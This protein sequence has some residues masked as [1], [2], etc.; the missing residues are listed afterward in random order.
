MN[1][2]GVTFLWVAVQAT[3]LSAVAA[4]CYVFAARRG[5]DSA[6][7]VTAGFLAALVVLPFLALCPLP[8]WHA[9]EASTADTSAMVRTDG[10]VELPVVPLHESSGSDRDEVAGSG[11]TTSLSA[12]QRSWQKLRRLGTELEQPRWQWHAF[13]ALAILAGSAV[14]LVRILFGMWALSRWCRGRRVDDQILLDLIDALRT[15]MGGPASVELRELHELSAPAT[16]G[17]LRPVILLPAEWRS[18]DESERRSVLAHEWAHVCRRDYLAALVAHICV[19][20][21]FYHPLV[22]WLAGRLHLQQELEADALGARCAGGSG[23]YLRALANLALRQ[24]GRPLGWPAR[25]F[26]SGTGTLKR[27]ILML[28][29]RVNLPESLSS[30]PQRALMAVLLAVTVLGVSTLRG[31]GQEDGQQSA[32]VVSNK[33]VA[34]LPPF[35]LRF[36]PP[37]CMGAVCLRPAVILG[38]PEF[39]PAV[40]AIELFFSDMLRGPEIPDGLGVRLEEIEQL[41]CIPRIETRKIKKGPQSTFMLGLNTVRTVKDFDWKAQV[42]KLVPE[43]EEVAYAGKTYLKLPR[44]P[45]FFRIANAKAAFCCYV[46]DSR[47]LVIDT[48]P[49]LRKLIDGKTA[50]P[51]HTWAE[52]WKCVERRVVAFAFDMQDK[53]WLAERRQPEDG[54]EKEELLILKNTTSAAFGIDVAERFVIESILRC[55]GTEAGKQVARVVVGLTAK[56]HEEVGQELK[57]GKAEGFALTFLRFQRELLRNAKA[58]S[59][60]AIIRWHTEARLDLAEVSRALVNTAAEVRAAE[61]KKEKGV[62]KK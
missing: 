32:A 44:S 61:E 31:A 10:I 48:E 52:D 49:N 36:L 39:R 33:T 7:R 27:R 19:A 35:D 30:R 12:L 53:S 11:L 56:G 45:V 5:P 21:H 58:E 2:L 1:Q 40:D 54:L 29:S 46:P 4:A 16:V 20:V 57:E 24:E 25:A 22:Y 26:L 47:T 14:A 51:R 38:R 41:V 9:W 3:L 18:W 15:A 28:R 62:D 60:G 59:D 8:S 23:P 50:A 55:A 17:W 13:L 42:K 37:D 34:E 6:A 43:V